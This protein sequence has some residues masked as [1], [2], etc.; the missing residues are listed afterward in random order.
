MITAPV[1]TARY[2]RCRAVK[3]DGVMSSWDAVKGTA[4]TKKYFGIGLPG[5]I[6][7]LKAAVT[8]TN[9]VALT[10]TQ[11]ASFTGGATAARKYEA[12]KHTAAFTLTSEATKVGAPFPKTD[13]A[14]SGTISSLTANALHHLRILGTNEILAGGVT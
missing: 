5:F 7:N 9:N 14:A 13:V 10:W 6:A 11:D 3:N 8:A 4:A 1:K 2:Y 12:Y